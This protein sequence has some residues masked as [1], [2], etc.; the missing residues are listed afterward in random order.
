M[1][2]YKSDEF[3]IVIDNWTDINISSPNHGAG[4]T[5]FYC[6]AIYHNTYKRILLMRIDYIL[7][8]FEFK[9]GPGKYDIIMYD[10]A[11]FT[12]TRDNNYVGSV[13]TSIGGDPTIKLLHGEMLGLYAGAKLSD[14]GH[15]LYLSDVYTK[16]TMN[17]YQIIRNLPVIRVRYNDDIDYHTHMMFIDI[18]GHRLITNIFDFNKSDFDKIDSRFYLDSQASTLDQYTRILTNDDDNPTDMMMSMVL[19]LIYTDTQEVDD[20]IFVIFIYSFD[21]EVSYVSETNDIHYQKWSI[22]NIHVEY[23]GGIFD[24]SFVEFDLNISDPVSDYMTT[25]SPPVMRSILPHVIESTL[26][27]DFITRDCGIVSFYKILPTIITKIPMKIL[28][29]L[30]NAKLS[31]VNRYKYKASSVIYGMIAANVPYDANITGQNMLK[32]CI[33]YCMIDDDKNEPYDHAFKYTAG[34]K[35]IT[36]GIFTRNGNKDVHSHPTTAIGGGFPELIFISDE[37]LK[38]LTD[39]I[40]KEY[41]F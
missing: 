10:N 31:Q 16:M 25:I 14:I 2:I 7:R 21:N 35:T 33:K 32:S 3:D 37:D 17:R 38:I 6:H 41:N 5:H 12:V 18:L 34:D 22:D 23:A 28:F 4:S 13:I 1:V 39:E 36:F 30:D 11:S 29:H 26:A 20:H 27:V 24:K 9:F 8:M 40:G 15:L 19:H